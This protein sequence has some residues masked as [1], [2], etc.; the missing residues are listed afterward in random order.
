[1]FSTFSAQ[2]FNV[3]TRRG[4]GGWRGGA[5]GAVGRLARW[6]GWRGGVAGAVGRLA[7]WGGWRGGAGGSARQHPRS[8]RPIYVMN[9]FGT[10]VYVLFY[11]ACLVKAIPAPFRGMFF[12]TFHT[13]F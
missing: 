3:H 12:F 7:R 13:G 6:G 8:S 5:A 2:K 9:L 1:M 11:F 10:D 4:W